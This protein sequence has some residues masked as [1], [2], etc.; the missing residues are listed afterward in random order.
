M[1]IARDYLDV[2]M[3]YPFLETL[4]SPNASWALE[5]VAGLSQ[6]TILQLM[7]LYTQTIVPT[8]VAWYPVPLFLYFLLLWFSAKVVDFAFKRWTSIYPGLSLENKHTAVICER[9]DGF[10]VMTYV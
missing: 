2:V 5:D 8:T 4:N 3:G 6:A 1:C 7:D 9:R 10:L